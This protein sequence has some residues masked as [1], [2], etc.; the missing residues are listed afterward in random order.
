[1][2]FHRDGLDTAPIWGRLFFKFQLKETGA[3]YRGDPG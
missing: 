3:A 1:M 2:K